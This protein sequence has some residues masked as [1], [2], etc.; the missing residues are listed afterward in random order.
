VGLVETEEAFYEVYYG[1]LMIGWFD[2]RSHLF[3][4]ERPRSKRHRPQEEA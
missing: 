3:A 1:P 4:P 2:G